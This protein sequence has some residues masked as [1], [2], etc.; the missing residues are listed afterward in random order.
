MGIFARRVYGLN[1]RLASYFMKSKK[2]LDEIEQKLLE[3]EVLLEEREIF[4]RA[5]E[6][7]KDAF[8]SILS[9]DGKLEVHF[10]MNNPCRVPPNRW[11]LSDRIHDTIATLVHL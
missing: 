3:R 2:L 11:L 10:T 4:L 7:F 9:A 8:N 5:I 6:A 1:S